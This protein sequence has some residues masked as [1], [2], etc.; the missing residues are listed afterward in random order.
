MAIKSPKQKGRSGEREWVGKIN[1]AF[2]G[3]NYTRNRSS[4]GNPDL[5]G[6]LHPGLVSRP[7]IL[8]VFFHEVKRRQSLNI[9]EELEKA[10]GDA[11][12]K[13]PYIAWRKDS[14]KWVV[15]L[16]GEDFIQLIELANGRWGNEPWGERS[17]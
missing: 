4:G 12:G 13:M 15:C 8:D 9:F 7:S 10:F 2:P 14:S 16:Y 17:K 6:D 3:A 1:K 11:R 5:K